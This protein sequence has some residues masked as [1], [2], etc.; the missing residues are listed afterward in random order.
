M[1]HEEASMTE[2]KINGRKRHIGVDAQGHLLHVQV[3]CANRH[4]GF[5]GI[6]VFEALILRRTLKRFES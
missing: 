6:E 4:V 2:K 1:N 5:V 3:G